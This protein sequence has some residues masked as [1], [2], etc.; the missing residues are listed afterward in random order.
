VEVNG[1][2]VHCLLL[3]QELAR[4]G[5][6]VTILCR[7]GAWI[8]GKLAG[9]SIRVVESD[10]RRLPIGDL[11]EG[12]RLIREMRIDVIHTHMTRAHNFGIWLKLVTGTPCVATAHSHI[13]HPH[14]WMA[15]RVIAVAEA[16][17]RY[18][19]THNLLPASRIVTVHGFVDVE[20]ADSAAVIGQDDARMRFGLPVGIPV[21]GM[22]GDILPRKG[23]LTAI[24]ALAML[25][26]EC[27][28]TRML[29]VGKPKGSPR[30]AAQCHSEA[31]RLCV[32]DAIDW[33][34]YRPDVPIAMRA[35]DVYILPSASEMFPVSLL[36][37]MAARRACVASAVGGIPECITPASTACWFGRGT[38][39]D[40][41]RPSRPYCG[42][43]RSAAS[44]SAA[45]G[46]RSKPGLACRARRRLWSRSWRMPPAVASARHPL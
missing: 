32:E 18:H 40:W 25:R 5:Q 42:I 7:R 44:W 41:H 45:R 35:L 13:V 36:E 46:K 14:W 34:G 16:T 22:I 38:H 15:D 12:S 28:E 23:Q 9:S 39:A 19:R 3:S 8:A 10:M 31:R 20:R 24:Q 6:Q 29:V 27:P 26:A 30:Y 43:R 11:L 2:V 33:A 37:A 17:R 1:A 21:V 4:R